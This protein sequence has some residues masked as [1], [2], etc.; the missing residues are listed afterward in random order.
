[1]SIK[2]EYNINSFMI[3]YYCSEISYQRELGEELHKITME[4]AS[5]DY[6][7]ET[8]IYSLEFQ[9]IIDFSKSKENVF[10]FEAGF[11]IYDTNVPE[12]ETDNTLLPIFVASLFPYVRNFITVITND[13]ESP[14]I[15][16]TLDLRQINLSTKIELSL[17]KE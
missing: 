13:S 17:G 14:V 9:V 5:R 3:G 1:M 6:D 8:G 12:D 11:K 10:L 16:P 4:V 7:V 2:D 15:I